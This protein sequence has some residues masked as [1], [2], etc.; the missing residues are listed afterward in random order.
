MADQETNST[1]P[2]STACQVGIK[3]TGAKLHMATKFFFE[4]LE[5]LRDFGDVAALI[6]V[7]WVI[8]PFVNFPICVVCPLLADFGVFFY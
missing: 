7:L 6:P 8:D 1:A 2:I 3:I 5:G 4:H